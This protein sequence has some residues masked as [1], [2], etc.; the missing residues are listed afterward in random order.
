MAT[1]NYQTAKTTG[2]TLTFT[3][4]AVGGDAVRPNDGAYVLVANGDGTST[5]VTV[6]V[7]GTDKYGLARPDITVSVAA[8]ATA[9]IGPF[10]SDLA[11][12]GLVNLTYSKVTSLTVA[13]F[14]G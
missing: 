6:V 12:S 13:A 1:L 4:A 14:I 8:G 10:P 2:T 7:P 11:S 3:A 5:T 9:V